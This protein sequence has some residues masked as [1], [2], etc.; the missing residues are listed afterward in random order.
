[1]NGGII[2]CSTSFKCPVV[3]VVLSIYNTTTTCT[4]AVNSC[5]NTGPDNMHILC[6]VH[7]EMFIHAHIFSSYL[8][9]V[10]KYE[11]CQVHV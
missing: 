10:R 3:I 5:A 7:Y 11:Q 4:I 8:H 6:R 1:M 9:F 2:E